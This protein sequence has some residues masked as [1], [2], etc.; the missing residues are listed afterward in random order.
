MGLRR[1][2]LGEWVAGASAAAL[3][4]SLFLPWL[5]PTLSVCPPVCEETLSGWEALTWA[6]IAMAVAAALGLALVVATVTQRTD[7]VPVAIAA[8]ATLAGLVSVALAVRWL[9]DA[10]MVGAWVGAAG[11]LGLTGGAIL[12][13][14]DERP[15]G[16]RPTVEPRR[17]DPPGAGDGREGPPGASGAEPEAAR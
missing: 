12:A 7:A 2:H 9:L 10:R 1:L 4:A 5:R 13:M 8:L 14:R 6:D 11:A 16:E 17:L 3:L 15:R